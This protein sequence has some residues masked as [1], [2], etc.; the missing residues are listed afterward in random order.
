MIV[1]KN[2]YEPDSYALCKN[3]N[4]CQIPSYNLFVL[5]LN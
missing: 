3:P 2:N 5:L 1:K 4:S